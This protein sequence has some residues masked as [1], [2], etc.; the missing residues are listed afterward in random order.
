MREFFVT[1][2]CKHHYFDM[3]YIYTLLLRYCLYILKYKYNTQ[4][5]C[6]Y[7]H[8]YIYIAVI[9]PFL[10]K[11]KTRHCKWRCNCNGVLQPC[12]C[13]T[14]FIARHTTD[15]NTLTEMEGFSRKI[16]EK[17]PKPQTMKNIK[18]ELNREQHKQ[19]TH[20]TKWTK[21]KG[22]KKRK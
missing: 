3:T 2:H 22:K 13:S 21:K 9:Y 19:Q 6:H 1:R 17:N 12:N 5:Q 20:I 18:E 7:Y 10:R 16:E 8:L 14:H 4:A 15:Q 11:K